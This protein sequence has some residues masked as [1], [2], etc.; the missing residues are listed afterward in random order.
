[1]IGKN[2]CSY[3]GSVDNDPSTYRITKEEITSMEVY[4]TK[5]E[6]YREEPSLL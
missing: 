5:R 1:M 2:S 4:L 6:G 3:W